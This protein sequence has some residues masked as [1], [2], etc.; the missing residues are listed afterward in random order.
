M[1]KQFVLIED[2]FSFSCFEIEPYN[3]KQTV[4]SKDYKVLAAFDLLKKKKKHLQI[5]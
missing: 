1:F 5:V 2:F 4:S 3:S